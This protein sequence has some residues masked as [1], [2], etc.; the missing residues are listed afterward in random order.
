MYDLP[1]CL[2]RIVIDTQRRLYLHYNSTLIRRPFD[3]RA[4]A[5]QSSLRSQCNV[6]R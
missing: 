5:R 1:N 3:G 4:T 6:T 2:L